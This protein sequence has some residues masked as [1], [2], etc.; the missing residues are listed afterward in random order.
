MAN[1]IWSI[2]VQAYKKYDGK[3]YKVYDGKQYKEYD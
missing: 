3:Q 2:N 1:S